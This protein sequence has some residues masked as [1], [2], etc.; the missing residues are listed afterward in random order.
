VLMAA[1]QYPATATP[2]GDR[3]TGPMI[4]ILPANLRHGIPPA[5]SDSGA[6]D[7]T[8]VVDLGDGRPLDS[9]YFLWHVKRHIGLIDSGTAPL[10]RGRTWCLYPGHWRLAARHSPA[11]RQRANAVTRSSSLTTATW[12]ARPGATSK[13]RLIPR[14]DIT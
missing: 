6:P 1:S 4:V 14:H 13:I 5:R 9:H 2:A 8:G 7:D 3:M 12:P 11:G 10:R